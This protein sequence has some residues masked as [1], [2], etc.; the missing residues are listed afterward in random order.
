MG[1]WLRCDALTSG[2]GIKETRIQ[3]NELKKKILSMGKLSPLS[4]CE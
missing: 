3:M 1:A 2:Q 4:A